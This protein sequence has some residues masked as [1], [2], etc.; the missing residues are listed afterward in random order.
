M[1]RATLIALMR[2]DK[3]FL[4]WLGARRATSSGIQF[5]ISF[6][7]AVGLRPPPFFR[8]IQFSDLA[9]SSTGL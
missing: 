1:G 8:L 6:S 2:Q 5:P 3:T 9:S 7:T 4:N